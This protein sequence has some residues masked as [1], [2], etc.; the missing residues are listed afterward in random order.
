VNGR[1]LLEDFAKQSR[2]IPGLPN[3]LRGGVWDLHVAMRWAID[4]G[5]GTPDDSEAEA[6]EKALFQ[7]RWAGFG[8]PMLSLTESLCSSLLLTDCSAVDP[9]AFQLPFPCFAVELPWPRTPFMNDR[10]GVKW[11]FVHRFRSHTEVGQKQLDALDPDNELELFEAMK[12]TETADTLMVRLMTPGWGTS[13]LATRLWPDHLLV[14]SGKAWGDREP[15]PMVTPHDEL[16]VNGALALVANLCLYVAA[17]KAC[18]PRDQKNK[19]A[20]S[21]NRTEDLPPPDRWVLGREIKL[22]PEIRDMAR[23]IGAVNTEAARKPWKLAARYVVRGHWRNQACGVG[24]LDHK[25]RWIEP[26]WKGPVEAPGMT[27][28]F[29]VGEET[30]GEKL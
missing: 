15:D 9:R 11:L 30:A 14:P 21:K 20:S 17:T 7:A 6:G 1:L 25:L 26:Y 27:R 22:A 13:L 28:S 5:V 29:T 3:T 24:M 2:R 12:T 8:W 19:A 23:M 10:G 16:L 18:V 4:N